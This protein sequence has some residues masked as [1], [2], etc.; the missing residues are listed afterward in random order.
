[1][2]KAKLF[3]DGRILEELFLSLIMY[4]NHL[5]KQTAMSHINILSLGLK[6]QIQGLKKDLGMCTSNKFSD[7]I[8][9]ACPQTT[10]TTNVLV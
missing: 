10:L 7:D 8:G 4:Q 1:M 2:S 3:L 6:D 5:L 9:V